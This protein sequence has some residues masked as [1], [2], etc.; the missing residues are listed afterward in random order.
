MRNY[1]TLDCYYA[2]NLAIPNMNSVW[3]LA[4]EMAD[5]SIRTI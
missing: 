3:I 5:W 2:L 1:C 4:S